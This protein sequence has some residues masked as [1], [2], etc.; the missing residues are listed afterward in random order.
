LYETGICQAGESKRGAVSYASVD[1]IF[2]VIFIQLPRGCVGK[3][4]LD[5]ASRKDR[6]AKRNLNE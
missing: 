1:Q 5:C 3:A 6:I 2:G 4:E